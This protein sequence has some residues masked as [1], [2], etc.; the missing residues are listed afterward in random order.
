MLTIALR[1]LKIN[2]YAPAVLKRLDSSLLRNWH[3]T[4]H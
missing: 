2:L 1:G 4:E 3:Y